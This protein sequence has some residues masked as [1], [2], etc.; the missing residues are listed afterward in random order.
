MIQKIDKN[1]LKSSLVRTRRIIADKFR[2][3]HTE[4][5]QSES[6]LQK[7]Y[8]VLSESLQ[9]MIKNKEEI[10]RKSEPEKVTALIDD[11]LSG[12]Q[13][14]AS[15]EPENESSN[16]SFEHNK[17][18]GVNESFV[19]TPKNEKREPEVDDIG[20][21]AFHDFKFKPIK[22]EQ[23]RN[24]IAK[25][26]SHGYEAVSDIEK[27]IKKEN[28]S[29]VDEIDVEKDPFDHLTERKSAKR[30]MKRNQ[31]KYRNNLPMNEKPMTFDEMNDVLLQA[32]KHINLPKNADSSKF[33]KKQKVV[34]KK[35]EKRR[36]QYANTR[37]HNRNTK[38]DAI[39]KENQTEMALF[40]PEDFNDDAEYNIPAVKRSRISV[41]VNSI[42]KSIRKIKSRKYKTS[43]KSGDGLE[44]KFIPYSENI[45]YE[46]YD[47]PN[48]LCDRLRLL[49]SSKSAGNTNH[50]QEINSIIEELRE[51]GIIV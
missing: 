45:V 31:I 48:E 36:N 17:Q 14:E 8:G 2:K 4:R 15:S 12:S 1:K 49:V 33:I 38:F 39:R 27:K 44:R 11:S 32:K 28:V 40:S 19:L 46:Y 5:L 13:N 41:P 6:K 21:L 18:L 47:D 50:D 43:V 20:N 34:Q 51:R 16:E 24:P 42:E 9:K 35:Q 25:R 7:R 37:K 10:Q 22:L 29:D 3:L 30:K 26:K 23:I